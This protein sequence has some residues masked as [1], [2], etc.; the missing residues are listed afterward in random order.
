MSH[1]TVLGAVR[2]FDADGRHLALVSQ[3]Q[4]RLLAMLCLRVGT[5]V[6]AVVLEEHLGLSPGALRTSISRLR[7]V[8]GTEA[9]LSGSAGYELQA[10]VDA[11]EY[12]QLVAE[13][14]NSDA[15]RALWCLARAGSLWQ[16]LAYD[17]FAHEPWA[18]SEARRLLELH[19]AA[20][21]EL[22]VLHLDA[23]EHAAA[24]ATLLPLI[25]EQPY[26][27][28]PRALL[29]RALATAGR[30]TEAL[31]E[32][33]EY[34][35]LLQTDIGTDP[36][37]MLVVLDRSIAAD[38]DL[39]ALGERGH[40][41]WS[42]R[43]GHPSLVPVASRASVPT[44]LSSFVGRANEMSEL[45]ALLRSAR[46]LT[47][48][49]PGGSGKSRLAMRLAVS[50]PERDASDPWWVE[51]G[52]LPPAADVAEQIAIDL[53][54]MPG[55]DVLGELERR[56]RGRRSLLV[57]DNAEHVADATA[58]LLAT[59]LSR[60]PDTTALITSR[61]PLGLTGEVVWRVPELS[62]PEDVETVTLDNYER[63]DAMRLFVVRAREARPGMVIDRS[64]L[65]EIA[66]ICR[67]LDG[68]PLAIEL[69]AARLRNVSLST[70]ADGLAEVIGWRVG[71]SSK[72]ARHATLRSSIE[73]SVGLV[74]AAEQR[75]LL[76]LAVFCSSFDVEAA[77]AVI[78]SVLEVDSSGNTDIAVSMATAA[79]HLGRLTDVGLLQF[80]DRSGRYRMLTIVRQLCSERARASGD[81]ERAEE[82]HAVHMATWCLAVGAGRLGIEHRRFL[83]R[84]P[85]VVAASSWA[86]THAHR[87][88]LYAICRGLAPVRSALG[89][90]ADFVATWTWLL[91]LEP[92]ERDPAWAE[93]VAALIA[94][95]TSQMFDTAAAADAVMSL[96]GPESGRAAAW[97]QRG[98]A[99]VPAYR[100]Q[101]AAIHA[102]A[103][104]LLARGDDLEASVYVGFA[105]Y[106]LALL[107]RL[108]R[109]EH[110]LDELRRLTR[111]HGCM[112]SV[113]SVGNG[114]AASIIAETL[115]GDLAAAMDRGNRPVPDDPAFSI[116]AA[117]ALAH[118]ALLAGDDATM[119]RALEWGSRGSFP[120]LDFLTPFIGC[121]AAL[122]R[123]D[124]DAAADLAE[125]SA[126]RFRVPAWHLFALPVLNTA[127]IAAGRRDTAFRLTSA[128]G[129]MFDAMDIAPQSSAAL[130]IG[131]AQVALAFDDVGERGEAHR[132]ALAALG[133]A[134]V[135]G[136]SLAVVD[137]LDLLAVA[138]ARRGEPAATR[139]AAAAGAERRRL[140]YRFGVAPGWSTPAPAEGGVDGGV[141]AIIRELLGRDV[142]A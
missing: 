81:L 127:L 47:I 116:T 83:Q 12:E 138:H 42:R 62:M 85:D 89:H 53:G 66:R 136:L 137:A 1:C 24:V 5:T 97:L 132:S 77:R 48:T 15:E 7:R 100:G 8:L 128:A 90:H 75:A 121:C 11:V 91:A 41:A 10:S 37:T 34:R 2:A 3:A 104:D 20:M 50:A 120:L 29:I 68:M 55:P 142:R 38:A 79:D 4:R 105:A 67:E 99:M 36:S 129:P 39:S 54:V 114:Y 69:A 43:R 103:I 40:P 46:I 19:A 72:P 139:I 98:V 112:F 113:D 33:Q 134:H 84:M 51:L 60:C 141:A 74:D 140:G 35:A 59:L 135:D 28:L 124:V 26:R 44:P 94:T 61:Q 31:R 17:E 118:A 119:H 111:R 18:E 22:A 106:M 108:D 56:L 80:D 123:E 130:G 115:R 88:T 64:S 101:P 125:Q 65:R 93:A 92:T 95:A 70:I 86:R 13:A 71:D 73:W 27:D 122:L 25:D 49:G 63:F 30:R 32:F 131:R 117:A 57:L 78:E 110:L 9:L 23:G 14:F 21:E 126:E 82:A 52:V 16:G 96:V 109:T 87:A 76:S 107:G 6:R 58:E 133:A 102:Y 45:G